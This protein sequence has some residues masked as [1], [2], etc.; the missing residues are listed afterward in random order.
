MPQRRLADDLI[1]C[2]I[3]LY[4]IKRELSGPG[5]D[6]GSYTGPALDESTQS[7]RNG[8]P[9]SRDASPPTGCSSTR[10]TLRA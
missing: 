8:C 10:S 4:V 7:G 9:S 1:I 5:S 6:Q 2:V 3:G